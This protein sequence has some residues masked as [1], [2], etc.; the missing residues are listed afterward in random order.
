MLL[1]GAGAEDVRRRSSVK[2]PLSHSA[3][4]LIGTVGREGAVIWSF[5][6]CPKLS[7]SKMSSR[8]K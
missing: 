1:N 7:G 4:A 8:G 2:Q 6:S 3:R 5:E